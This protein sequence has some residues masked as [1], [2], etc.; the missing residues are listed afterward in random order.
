MKRKAL[1]SSLIVL[2]LSSCA[3]GIG[4]SSL[5]FSSAPD[6][7]L[8]PIRSSA[9]ASSSPNDGPSS[10]S[11][12]KSY[13]GFAPIE[14]AYHLSFPAIL[15]DDETGIHTNMRLDI[16]EQYLSFTHPSTTFKKELALASMAFVSL[17]PFRERIEEA[18]D[19][20][21]FEDLVFSEDYD[22]E[23]KEDTLLYVL[24][25]KSE[26]EFEIVN[27]TI[28]GYE[29][30]KPWVENFNI[31]TEGNHAGFNALA[32]KVLVPLISYLR[33]GFDLSKTKL[34]INAYSR[35]A[36]V[37]NILS[38][39]LLD[40]RYIAE[41][42]LYAY[43]FS[44]PHG[45]DAAKAKEHPSVFNILHSADLITHVSPEAYGHV[46]IGVDIDIS[47]EFSADVIASYHP[48]LAIPSFTANDKK[49]EKY[50]TDQEF[51]S[52]FLSLLLAPSDSYKNGKS[53]IDI[54]TRANFASSLQSE[55]GYLI[56]L[57]FSLPQEALDDLLSLTETIDIGQAASL[58]EEDGVFNL[59]KPILDEH[60][61][62]Y[63]EETLKRS[64]SKLVRAIGEKPTLAAKLMD[65]GFRNNLLRSIYFHTLECILPLLIN[66]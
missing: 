66:L 19:Y 57:G 13:P 16:P 3:S 46:R 64:V 26:G 42:N 51:V 33:N 32:L 12:R 15:F 14:D 61:V 29:Y 44:T 40:N 9:N 4:G 22:L 25:H 54:S 24:G 38:A 17:A 27:L 28:A 35:S 6:A 41:E 45:V 43:L 47:H 63:D 20:F 56:A 1:L 5:Y 58:L 31:G 2:F 36:A 10:S 7:S 39:T 53:E 59:L 62:E 23:E 11:T 49:D 50:S 52:Y 30:K 34:Y 37:A 55:L 48:S 8:S 21:S 60:E 65:E 18:Y